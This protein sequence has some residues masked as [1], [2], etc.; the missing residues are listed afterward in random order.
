MYIC[1]KCIHSFQQENGVNLL[2]LR[3]VSVDKYALA[4]MN[5]LFSEEEMAWSCFVESKRSTKKSL[6]KE[7]IQKMKG[8]KFSLFV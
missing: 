8:K 7:K 3:A 6:N 2:M 1:F 5:A 4:L